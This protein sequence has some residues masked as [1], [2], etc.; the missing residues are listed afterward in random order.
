MSGWEIAPGLIEL[1]K[2][3]ATY[4][5]MTVRPCQGPAGAPLPFRPVCDRPHDLQG[6]HLAPIRR[7]Q[8]CEEEIYPMD[9]NGVLR[10]LLTTHGFRMDGRQFDNHNQELGRV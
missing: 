8:A 6:R 3:W 4:Q 2:D 10:H 5:D 1:A 9:Q 7:C